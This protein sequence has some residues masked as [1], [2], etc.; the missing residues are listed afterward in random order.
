[1][2]VNNAI[3]FS[4]KSEALNAFV[5]EVSNNLNISFYEFENGNKILKAKTF[6]YCRN[7]IKYFEEKKYAE[8]F[9]YEDETFKIIFNEL[10][11]SSVE[12]FW[13]EVRNKNKG[14]GTNLLNNILD[15]ADELNLEIKAIPIPINEMSFDWDAKRRLREWYKSFNFKSKSSLTPALFYS[16]NNL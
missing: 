2:L 10:S 14:I 1:M 11:D 12:L 16:P 4:S 5:R 7:Q 3:K 8:F 6:L 9:Q 13:I 15:A